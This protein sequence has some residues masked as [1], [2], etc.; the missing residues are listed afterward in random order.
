MES[1]PGSFLESAED[2]EEVHEGVL[3]EGHGGKG[4]D[5]DDKGDDAEED[6]VGM[7]FWLDGD[8]GM[9]HGGDEEEE[10]PEEPTDPEEGSGEEEQ[11]G[12]DVGAEAVEFGGDGVEDVS[13]VELTAGNEIEGSDEEADPSGDEDGVGGDVFEGGSLGVPANEQGMED[14]DGEGFAAEADDGDGCVGGGM[15]TEGEPDGDGHG[16]GDIAGQR[17]V[18]AHVHE[19]VEAGDAGSNLDDGA[20]GTAEGGCGK[21]PGE[22]DFDVVEAAGEVVS[23]LVDEEDAEEGGGES[24][25]GEEHFGMVREPGP[26]PEVTVSDNGRHAFDKVLHE[27]RA[28]GRSGDDTGGQ[29]N[30]RQAI[31]PKQITHLTPLRHLHEDFR[32]GDLAGRACAESPGERAAAG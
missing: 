1:R 25:A 18:D 5:E 17:A 32:A 12:Q 24:P 28:V 10:S 16:G 31:L 30:Q 29:Q 11:E 19:G 7:E 21:D 22:S 27:A 2:V 14:A 6:T 20:G 4:E 13:A 3:V 9:A 23:E 8:L 15:N 26:G